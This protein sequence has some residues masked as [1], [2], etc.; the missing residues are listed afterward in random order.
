MRSH[1]VLAVVAAATGAGCQG[2]VPER[3]NPNDSSNRPRAVAR[4]EQLVPAEFGAHRLLVDD[5]PF[6]PQTA[7]G[8]GPDT[9]Y[10][11]IAEESSD[12]NG[13]PLSVRFDIGAEG[14]WEAASDAS[15]CPGEVGS[16][17]E[18]GLCGIVRPGDIDRALGTIPILVRVDDGDGGHDTYG[19]S[20]DEPL[21]IRVE[22]GAPVSVA[23]PD[24]VLKNKPGCGDSTAPI[25]AY[26]VHLDGTASYD[27]DPLDPDV[28]IQSYCWE[29]RGDHTPAE[30]AE[31]IE[32]LGAA[33]TGEAQSPS[34]PE[35]PDPEHP[36]CTLR[37][38]ALDLAV[39]G[40]IPQDVTFT[41]W[42]TDGATWGSDAVRVRTGLAPV[43]T[44]RVSPPRSERIATD[45]F[46]IDSDAYRFP[47]ETPENDPR[48]DAAATAANSPELGPSVVVSV[49]RNTGDAVIEATVPYLADVVA[50][51]EA[52]ESGFRE[53]PIAAAAEVSRDFAAGGLVDSIAWVWTVFR[54]PATDGG[55]LVTLSSAGSPA[56]AHTPPAAI[57]ERLDLVSAGPGGTLYA[58]RYGGT[59]LFRLALDP[60][61]TSCGAPACITVQET[62]DGFDFIGGLAAAPDGRVFVSNQSPPADDGLPAGTV[63]ILL[64]TLE[65]WPVPA[66]DPEQ[67]QLHANPIP[68]FHRPDAIRY[69]DFFSP[70]DLSEDVVFVND[71]T[72]GLHVVYVTS[73]AYPY[74]DSIPRGDLA[75][76]RFSPLITFWAFGRH[77][78]KAT[79]FDGLGGS[80]IGTVALDGPLSG[81]AASGFF[82]DSIVVSTHAPDGG[83]TARRIGID[84]NA[85]LSRDGAVA[86]S[87]ADRDNGGAWIAYASPPMLVGASSDG[88]MLPGRVLADVVLPDDSVHTLVHPWKLSLGSYDRQLWLVD[89]TTHRQPVCPQ[90]TVSPHDTVLYFSRPEVT[91]SAPPEPQAAGPLP[92][93][94]HRIRAGTPILDA[95]DVP[96]A[97][98]L[99][100]VV[101]CGVE[102]P[103]LVPALSAIYVTSQSIG[104][105]P[106]YS[107][108]LFAGPAVDGDGNAWIAKSAN[109][110]DPLDL[111]RDDACV[112]AV[113]PTYCD[114]GVRLGVA[115]PGAVFQWTPPVE[116]DLGDC[117]PGSTCGVVPADVDFDP[118][119]DRLWVA[120]VDHGI[121][122]ADPLRQP[123]TLRVWRFSCATGEPLS[124]CP[125]ASREVAALRF[126]IETSFRL[127]RTGAN[128]RDIAHYRSGNALLAVEHFTGT[129]FL[130]DPAAG[131]VHLIRDEGDAL[132]RVA[133]FEADDAVDLSVP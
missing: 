41:L 6:T 4:I 102:P 25:C 103:E 38:H 14:A 131:K 8:A 104:F 17:G 107:T 31:R 2:F 123:V 119:T 71:A 53:A 98:T 89:A 126:P 29:L 99:G 116:A 82:N 65:L 106:I 52:L 95:D 3:D 83:G 60:G 125:D 92:A 18:P 101:D 90:A 16:A 51:A 117:V 67:G 133:T 33:T 97:W 39:R 47:V 56:F 118:G 19:D 75:A 113:D 127:D 81:V 50:V 112:D 80:V 42:V 54:D 5:Q 72:V 120:A 110:G 62:S 30:C 32:F 84:A 61:D 40:G 1:V 132:R 121:R 48:P 111:G 122:I 93:L 45:Y 96:F 66:P 43:W 68:G 108:A 9:H 23:G 86:D 46:A 15:P 59:R 35:S 105:V 77:D 74:T 109:V 44:D 57:D 87:A 78:F 34:C 79:L 114:V 124:I 20:A 85:G 129:A 73:L 63:R 64:P 69:L 10:V 55:V 36:R 37:G 91:E 128:E 115:I 130:L 24:W 70:S 49:D 11:I 22:D 13:D 58:A 12:P 28:T 7:G 88:A 94:L 26:P 21:S 100:E 76:M 27:P